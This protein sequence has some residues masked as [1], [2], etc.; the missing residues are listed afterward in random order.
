MPDSELSRQKAYGRS[1]LLEYEHKLSQRLFLILSD[2]E[3]HGLVIAS[4]MLPQI[5]CRI[6][7]FLFLVF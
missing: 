3:H 2:A 7:G 5:V 4:I 1:G 6:V